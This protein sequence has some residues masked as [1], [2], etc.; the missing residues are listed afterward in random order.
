MTWKRSVYIQC[1]CVYV[2]CDWNCRWIMRM[3]APAAISVAQTA[4]WAWL[5]ATSIAH[6]ARIP[7]SAWESA[8]VAL[9]QQQTHLHPRRSQLGEDAGVLYT[10]LLATRRWTLSFLFV[11]VLFRKRPP[12]AGKDEHPNQVTFLCPFRYRCVVFFK[13]S[14]LIFTTFSLCVCVCICKSTVLVVCKF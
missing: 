6:R 13:F 7:A 5:P 11:C 9:V 4:T 1:E 8:T 3:R 12:A 14:S 2:F 10:Q